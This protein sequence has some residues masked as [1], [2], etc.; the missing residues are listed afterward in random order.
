MVRTVRCAAGTRRYR[1]RSNSVIG[2]SR[3]GTT[4]GAVRWKIVSRSTSGWISGTVW[5]ADAPVPTTATLRPAKSCEWS[6]LAVWKATPWKSSIP[7]SEGI[8]G[9]LRGPGAPTSTCAENEPFDVSICHT[10]ASSSHSAVRT[11]HE[12]RM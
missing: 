7:G 4:H 2:R 10:L 11:G 3:W 1:R 6:H 12:N 9:S 5:I 8:E